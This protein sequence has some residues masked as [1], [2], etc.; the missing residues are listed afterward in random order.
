MSRR[1]INDLQSFND[2]S[3]DQE[4]QY[5]FPYHYIPEFRGGYKQYCEWTWSKNYLSALEFILGE[6][7]K[8]I[9]EINS[10]ADIGCGDGRLTRELAHEFKLDRLVGIDYS[11]KALN[12][13]KALNPDLTFW[14]V[15]IVQ[16]EIETEFDAIT[17]IE[18]FE[19]ILP[20]KC[21]AFVNAL[22]SLLNTDGKIY[23][24]VPHSNKKIGHKHFQHF[25]LKTLSN[26]FEECFELVDIKYIQKMSKFTTLISRLFS[27]DQFII[28]NKTINNILYSLYKK[29]AFFAEENNCTRIY[30]KLRKKN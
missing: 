4:T 16:S 26:Y 17:L 7:K 27:N 23:L 10:I 14:N 3:A 5:E 20:E 30:M 29:H 2:C 19:H 28:K 6:I 9:N 25:T 21:Y 1:N 13:A 12:I 11:Q 22:S 24:T 15:D 18:V 8:D